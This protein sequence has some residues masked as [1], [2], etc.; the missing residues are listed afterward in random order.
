LILDATWVAPKFLSIHIFP[1][2]GFI[3][4]T[5]AEGVSLQNTLSGGYVT[6]LLTVKSKLQ[7]CPPTFK[8][9]LAVPTALGVP[10]IL[11]VKVPAPLAKVPANKMAIKPVTP[12]DVMVCPLCVPPLPP[13]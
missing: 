12:V 4:S 11:Y 8:V 6:P 3:T 10:V 13:V 2:V 1:V 7:V 9:K 5:I